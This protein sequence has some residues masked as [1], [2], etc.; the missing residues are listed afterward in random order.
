MHAV[1]YAALH[2]SDA[3]LRHATATNHLGDY[4]AIIPN[5]IE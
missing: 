4:R 1:R 5:G 2:I 3:Y